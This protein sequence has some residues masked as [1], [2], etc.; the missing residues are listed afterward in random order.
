MGYIRLLNHGQTVWNVENK[1]TGSTDI[2]L[3]KKVAEQAVETRAENLSEYKQISI[4][5]PL[6]S[7]KNHKAHFGNHG[8]SCKKQ[9]RD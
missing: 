9:S 4:C 8:N 1:I 5:S 6:E 7:R 3:T 2:D